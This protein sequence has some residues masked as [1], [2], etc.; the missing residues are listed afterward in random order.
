[1]PVNILIILSATY[2]T[3]CVNYGSHCTPAVGSHDWNEEAMEVMTSDLE[4][5]WTDLL[6]DIEDRQERARILIQESFDW[7]RQY[8]GKQQNHP[9]VLFLF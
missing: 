7:A 2:S 8:L 5:R 3:F 4:L 9:H 1:M 6:G